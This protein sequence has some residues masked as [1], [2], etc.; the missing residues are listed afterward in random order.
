MSINPAAKHILSL[1]IEKLD[2]WQILTCKILLYDRK[3]I[4]LKILN[5][6]GTQFSFVIVPWLVLYK[7]CVFCVEHQFH[8][9]QQNEQLST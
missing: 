7:M 9:Y 2:R 8:Q 6:V 3:L 1:T 4:C 5:N